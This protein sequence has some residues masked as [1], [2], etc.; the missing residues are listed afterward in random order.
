VLIFRGVGA[1]SVWG[2]LACVVA[3]GAGAW[4][5]VT[6]FLV[7]YRA[8]SRIAEC[9]N[10][11]VVAE[12][13]AHLQ[14]L[15]NQI[16]NATGHW[17]TAQDQAGKTVAT[18]GE[19]ADR[20]ATE[21][22]AFTEFLQKANDNERANLRLEIEKLRRA[23]GDWLQVVTRMLDHVFA[24]H[25]AAVRSG[26]SSLIEQLGQFQNAC[27]DAVRRV[28]LAAFIVAPDELFDEKLHQLVDPQQTLL[29]ASR[30]AETVATGYTY[31]GQLLRRALVALQPG[32]ATDAEP[33]NPSTAPPGDG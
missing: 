5:A 31:Q 16:Q 4:L 14:A 15:A 6:P 21:A 24:L 3:V 27:R 28:G 8:T 11:H 2:M 12:R 22:K 17:Q 1:L 7:E 19:I 9:A 25:Q 30:V 10:L 13:F 23:E 32:A 29:P 18:A 26:Q 20:I 33:A